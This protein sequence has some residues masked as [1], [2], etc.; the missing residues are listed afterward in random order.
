MK[1]YLLPL[2]GLLLLPPLPAARAQTA[3][4]ALS[5]RDGALSQ[6][7]D[8]LSQREIDDLRDAA[9]EPGVRIQVFTAILNSR[10]KRLEDLLAKRRNHTDFASEMHDTLDQFG[11]VTDELNDNLDDYNRRHRDVRKEL[12]KLLAATERWSATLRSIGENEAFNVVRR[13]AL[14]DVGDTNS[15]AIAL[16]TDLTAYFKAHPE[17]AASEKKRSADPH[18]VRS[19]GSPE[20]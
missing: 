2:A 20:P 8:A 7:D 10:Q 14:D 3:D 13:I 12:P 1:P 11:K 18:A 6:R 5:Q 16:G 19:E 17:A 15:L 9:F 4:G